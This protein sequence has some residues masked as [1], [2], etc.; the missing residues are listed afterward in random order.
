MKRESEYHSSSLA[1]HTETKSMMRALIVLLLL[2]PPAVEALNFFE[3]CGS[4]DEL[5]LTFA[6]SSTVQPL[7]E[8]WANGIESECPDMTLL[9]EGG[10]SSVGARRV[11]NADDEDTSQLAAAALAAAVD[12]GGMSREWNTPS[13][14]S[15]EDGWNYDCAVKSPAEDNRSGRSVIQVEVAYD[16]ISVA[17]AK[18]SIADQCIR[19]SLIGGVNNGQLR[20]SYGTLKTVAF[21]YKKKGQRSS[22]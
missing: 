14:S 5:P 1:T 21:K 12:I 16:G 4:S 15:T 8:A 9:I 11:C 20:L 2:L 17:V 3:G 6:G 10:G 7:A 19:V 22:P 13:E 18:G